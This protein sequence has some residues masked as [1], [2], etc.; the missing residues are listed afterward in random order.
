MPRILITGASGFTGQ[1]ACSHFVKLGFDVSAVTTGRSKFVNDK[2]H[3]E[4]CDLTDNNSVRMLVKKVKPQYLL[5]LA[6][7]NH[8][9]HSWLDPVSSLEV[10]SISTLYLVE[11]LRHES[12]DCKIVI[13]GSALQFNPENLSTLT[14]PYS[15]SKTLQVLI[16]QAWAV[17]YKMNIIIAKPSNLI[18]PG[19]SNGVCS[20]FA[21]KI[22]DMEK[23][24]SEC[25]L[26]VNNLNAQRDFVDVRDAVNAYGFLLKKGHSGEIYE[27]ASGNSY[28]LEEIIKEFRR[29]T[30]IN[31]LLNSKENDQIE[32]S[33]KIRPEKL[34]ALGWQ[35]VFPLQSSLKDILTFYRENEL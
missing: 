6:G 2:L 11:A 7:Q 35:P 14:H 5:H 31:F 26:Q 13:I 3:I 25:I 22:V 27:I 1:H 33:V 24:K 17:L 20:I 32:E 30:S 28:S 21:K 29:L 10:N 19:F 18:G 12:P 4:R 16:A 23:K 9:G 15:L 34:T 8:V